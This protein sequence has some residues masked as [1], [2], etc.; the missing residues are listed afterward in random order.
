MDDNA[1]LNNHSSFVEIISIRTNNDVT[2]NAQNTVNIHN[3]TS[4]Q[5]KQRRDTEA[6][7]ALVF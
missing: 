2:S 3:N 5:G 7:Y 6:M 4:Y 1:R